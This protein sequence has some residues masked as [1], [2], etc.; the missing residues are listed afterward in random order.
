MSAQATKLPRPWHYI[1]LPGMH[2]QEAA[3]NAR[4]LAE[5]IA[6]WREIA[7]LRLAEAGKTAPESLSDP[8]EVPAALCGALSRAIEWDGHKIGK[9]LELCCRWPVDFDLCARL[10]RWSVALKTKKITAWKAAHPGKSKKSM[11]KPAPVLR[12]P[13]GEAA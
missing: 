10:Q 11:R 6:P 12:S 8:L 13:E 5:I 1:P 9:E 7:L 3:E 2:V 4:K